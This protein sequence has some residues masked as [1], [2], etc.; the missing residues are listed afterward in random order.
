MKKFLIKVISYLAVLFL[1]V[2]AYVFGYV[3]TRPRLPFFTNSVC[4][5]AKAKFINEH[6]VL[7]EKSKMV[8][9][10]SSM[11]LYNVDCQ[12]MQ[13]SLHIPIINLSSWGLKFYD[14]ENFPIWKKDKDI[15][16]NMH[17]TDFG[18]SPI[19]RYRGFPYSKSEATEYIN[20]FMNF[21]TYCDHI[22]KYQSY[23][24]KDSVDE[25]NSLIFDGAGSVIV[26]DK[27]FKIDS[28][29]WNMTERNFTKQ[30]ADDLVATMTKQ[31]KKINRL[32]IC[33]SPPRPGRYE[34]EKS[35]SVVELGN[36][37]KKI[38]NVLFFNYYDMPVTNS[39][40]TDNCHMTG[41]GARRYTKKII[42]DLRNAS[43]FIPDKHYT[44]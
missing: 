18:N 43:K 35:L 5:N 3:N 41:R 32:I 39:D 30:Q 42:F 10:G 9:I 31:A 11:D 13:D 28:N 15:F 14:F 26:P 25:Y 29:R 12:Q 16:I 22:S 17:F 37:L 34:K 19:F 38:H 24:D 36:R 33:F 40:F 7:L 20:I 6:A 1:I 2:C 8:V 21:A 4:F 44:F 27:N 23:T